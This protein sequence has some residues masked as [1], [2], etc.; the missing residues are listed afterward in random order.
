[1]PKSPWEHHEAVLLAENG[2]RTRVSRFSLPSPLASG[3][4]RIQNYTHDS[5][6]A[7]FSLLYLCEDREHVGFINETDCAA[8]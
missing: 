7:S 3:H 6:V 2:L 1:M 5:F 4:T 8:L